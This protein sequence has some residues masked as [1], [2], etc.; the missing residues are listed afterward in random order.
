MATALTLFFSIAST[1]A[2]AGCLLGV[3]DDNVRTKLAKSSEI[4]LPIL[5][6]E[7]VTKAVLPDKLRMS[8]F[9]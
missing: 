6:L 4:V 1:V 8:C 2:K 3:I 9:Q 7:P 5:R